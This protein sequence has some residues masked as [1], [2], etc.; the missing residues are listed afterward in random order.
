MVVLC[1]LYGNANIFIFW[2]RKIFVILLGNTSV[3][4]FK[5]I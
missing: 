2:I 1:I 5:Y 3:M 4:I